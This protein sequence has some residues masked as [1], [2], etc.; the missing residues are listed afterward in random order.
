M[1]SDIIDM[2]FESE[3]LYVFGGNENQYNCK[4]Q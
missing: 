4:K 3:F 1:N 2:M